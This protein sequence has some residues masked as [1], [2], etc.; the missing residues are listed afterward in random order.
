[1]LPTL[2]LTNQSSA[3]PEGS[4]RLSGRAAKKAAIFQKHFTDFGGEIGSTVFF[5]NAT[6]NRVEWTVTEVEQNWKDCRWNKGAKIPM[7][8]HLERKVLLAGGKTRYEGVWAC[9]N[10][11]ANNGHKESN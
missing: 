7:F 6:K 4:E 10:Q 11:L 3:T 9:T 2:A 1:M 5:K 8:I